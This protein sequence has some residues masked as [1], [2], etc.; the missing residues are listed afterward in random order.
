MVIEQSINRDCRALSG[1]TGLK[2]N[3]A[4]MKRWVLK[5][6]LK[7]NVS[8]V[9]KTMLG[10]GIDQQSDPHKEKNS[11][12]FCQIIKRPQ[13]KMGE[14]EGG[15]AAME[16]DRHIMSLLVIVSQTRDTNLETLFACVLSAVPLSVL[17]SDGKMRKC[18]KSDLLKEIE[19]ALAVENL[20]DN[21]K[22]TLTL[23][24]FMVLTRMI[25][26]ET[27]KCKTFGKLSDVL[28][29]SYRNV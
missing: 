6:H 2:T 25:C 3:R 11:C 13:L 5:A 22:I 20:E 18:C 4:A 29:S 15:T 16:I 23:I 8:T 28:L 27:L 12:H 24:A 9:T 1:L 21:E 19:R 26:I 7:A 14:G 10:P 17:N